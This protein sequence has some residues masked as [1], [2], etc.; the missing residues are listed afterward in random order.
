MR[1]LTTWLNCATT[2]ESLMV[3]KA[4]KLICTKSRAMDFY[5]A[6][7]TT[8]PIVG[9]HLSGTNMDEGETMKVHTTAL[10]NLNVTNA[11]AGFV[12]GFAVFI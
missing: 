10:K 7:G 9:E 12:T 3:N 8:V 2:P 4:N 5:M 1:Y 6:L 11:C